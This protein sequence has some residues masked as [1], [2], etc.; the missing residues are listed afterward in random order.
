MQTEFT[1]IGVT[2]IV[3][4][5]GVTYIGVGAKDKYNPFE[6]TIMGYLKKIVSSDHLRLTS[7]LDYSF[8]VMQILCNC[9]FIGFRYT[10]GHL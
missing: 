5:I 2:C 3:T 1:C 9:Q 6:T 8:R 7:C 10:A 4:C